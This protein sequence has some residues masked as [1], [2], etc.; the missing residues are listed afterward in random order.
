MAVSPWH[1]P[2]AAQSAANGTIFN[3]VH[4]VDCRQDFCDVVAAAAENSV[5]STQRQGKIIGSARGDRG[6]DAVREIPE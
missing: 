6:R 2:R 1:K 3:L 5:D 4:R